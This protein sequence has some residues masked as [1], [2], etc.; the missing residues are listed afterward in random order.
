MRLGP[1]D[2]HSRQGVDL[3]EY[4][5][6][7]YGYAMVL[8]RNTAEAEDLVQETCLRALRGMHGLRD[9]SSAKAWLF[10]ILR[11]IWLN[12]LR[13]WRAAPAMVELDSDENRAYEPA[14]ATQDP[15]V[16]YVARVERE[17]VRVAIQ[18]LPVEYREIIILREYE[19]LSYQQIA[20]VLDCPPGTVMSRLA[21]ARL[22]LR[23]L[24][25]A[26]LSPAM[27][28]QEA[29]ETDGTAA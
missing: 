5:D 16:D 6:G 25:T 24:L 21:R 27:H 15:H 17:Q 20:A 10:T 8:S 19:E 9:G 18:K 12:Q 3:N 23:Q 28:N 29:S 7:L 13:Q 26:G 22:K 4:L 2:G 11:N 1:T 14:D